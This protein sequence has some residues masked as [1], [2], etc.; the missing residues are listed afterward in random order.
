ML[1]T[2]NYG[3]TY[4]IEVAVKTNGAYSG[5]GNGCQITAPAVPSI[6]SCGQTIPTPATHISTVSLAKVTSYRF[7]ITNLVSNNVTT[8][9]RSVYWF[10]FNMVPGFAPATQY[11][12]RVAV[13]TAGVYSLFSD[14]CEIT[15]PGYAKPTSTKAD[16]I[17]QTAFSVVAYPNPFAENFM[18]DLKTSSEA[19]VNIKVYDMTGRLLDVRTVEVSEMESQEIGANYPA[20][21]YNVIVG[22]GDEVKTLRVVKR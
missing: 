12:V 4:I 18:I 7:E 19:Q 5:F 15:S 17:A 10:T 20:G 8:L 16:A 6:T 14:A 2:Y 13:M 3:T 22:Q 1:A 21:V 11:G 9:D